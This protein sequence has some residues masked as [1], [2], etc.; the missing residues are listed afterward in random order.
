MKNLFICAGLALVP[1]ISF[2]QPNNPYNQK[3]IDYVASV[4]MIQNDYNAGR[5]RDFN[6]ETLEYYSK[7]IPLKNQASVEVASAI[8]K[9]RSNGTLDFNKFIGG[10]SLS[11]ISKQTLRDIILNPTALT[12]AAYKAS[13][14]SKADAIAGSNISGSEKELVLSLIAISYNI[15]GNIPES[16]AALA[17]GRGRGCWISGPYGEGPG[18][19]AQCI[20]AGAVVGGVIGWSICG[21]LCS[22][23]GAIIGGVAGA[24]S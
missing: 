5:A 9:T 24:L 22:L 18:T 21:V 13:L 3:G 19:Q 8:I 11:E 4:N 10:T 7:S 20:A 23:G 14:T 1:F 16:F 2:A 15:P 17:N 6:E 12:D